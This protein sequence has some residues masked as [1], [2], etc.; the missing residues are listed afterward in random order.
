VANLNARREGDKMKST[1]GSLLFGAATL[2]FGTSAVAAQ[3]TDIF[4]LPVAPKP[5][6]TEINWAGTYVGAD[7]G[8]MFGT[9]R[10]VD[11]GVLVEKGADTS[12]VM[13]GLL[14][15]FNWQD[16]NWVYGTEVDASIADVQGHGAIVEPLRY[17]LHWAANGRLRLGYTV[18][19][20]TLLFVAGGIAITDLR[21]T[22]IDFV[23]R[24]RVGWTIGAGVEQAFNDCLV[25]RVEFLYADYGQIRY[26][27]GPSDFYLVNFTA[28]QA[29]AA[30][31]WKL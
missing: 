15:G 27:Q 20:D 31:V 29:R 26:T 28:P 13:G 9:T 2:C 17:A 24:T 1:I 3:S 10:V 5:A 25:G 21:F 12:G 16:G 7:V 14:A 19:P 4:A 8:G 18:T 22:E 11:T 6:S 23:G 30:L